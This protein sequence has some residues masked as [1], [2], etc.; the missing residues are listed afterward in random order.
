MSLRAKCALLLLAFELTLG[1]TI[2][3]TV[4]TIR[5]YFK[6]AADSFRTSNAGVVDIS[7]LRTLARNELTTLLQFVPHPKATAQSEQMR[8]DIAAA[9]FDVR[10][11]LG[12]DLDH[13]VTDDL[14]ARLRACQAAV[15]TFLAR[16][17]AEPAERTDRFDA[18]PH[19]EL[20]ALL[21]RLEAHVLDEVRASV[22]KTFMAQENAILILGLNMVVGAALGIAGMILV[23]RWVLLPVAELKRSTDEL[24]R[25]NLSHKARVTSRDELGRLAAAFN[26]MSSDISR[27]ERQM[28]QR[29]RLAAM[30]ELIAYVA[31]NIRNPLAGIQSSAD[32]CRRQLAEDSPLRT[33]HEDIV[34]AIDKFQRWLRQLEQTCSPLELNAEPTDIRETVDNVVAVFRPMSER[35]SIRVACQM[36]DSM[37]MVTID[38]RHFEQALAA[39]IGNAIEAA[40]DHGRVTISVTANGDASHWMLA[41]ADTG[42]GIARDVRDLIFEPAYSTKRTGHG[43]GLSMAKRIVDLHGG[44]LSVDCPPEG[45]TVFSMTMPIDAGRE[46]THA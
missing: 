13:S 11:D 39:I 24:G 20:D 22:D 10:Q 44:E 32:S 5:I 28:I 46:M 17:L 3:L 38:G 45:G 27:I 33:H 41:V 23:R 26:Q 6:D 8:R 7:R 30:G 15:D 31:H 35:R 18:E 29:E 25:G 43:L 40:G 21:G 34:Y 37:R 2:L 9:A 16:S 12:A 14:E 4:R 1:A 42:P 36:P 19:L